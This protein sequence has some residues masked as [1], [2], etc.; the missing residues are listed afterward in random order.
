MELKICHLYPDALNLYG[1]RGNI[2]CLKRRCEARN[3]KCSVTEVPIGDSRS[4]TGYDLYFIGGGQDFEQKLLLDDLSGGKKQ[5]IKSAVNDGKVFLAICGGY[6]LLGHYYKMSDGSICDYIGAVD[7]YTE[8]GNTRFIGNTVCSTDEAGILIGFENHAG[9]TYLGNDVMPL[10][11]VLAGG[12]NNGEDKTEGAHFLNVFGTYY[13]GPVLPKNPELCDLLLQT[14]LSEKYGK[15]DL[16]ELN[17]EF[18]NR[19][20]DTMLKRLGIE[21]AH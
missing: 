11:N 10:G 16:A 12:G 6:Q 3:I 2:I 1:D 17:D 8:A 20:R 18:E 19:A 5:S 13:H 4:L 14:A 9:R 7:L 15:C 21:A